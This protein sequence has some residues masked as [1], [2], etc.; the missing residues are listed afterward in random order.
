MKLGVIDYQFPRGGAERFVLGVF[1]SLPADVEVTVFSA[2]SA[3]AGYR[4]LIAQTGR[5]IALVERP[6]LMHQ[7]AAVAEDQAV[8]SGPQ[9]YDVPADLWN[10]LDLVWFPWV[11]RHLIPRECFNRTVATIHD[12]IIV[13]LGEFMAGKREAVGRVGHFYSM[14]MEDMLVRRLMGSLAKVMV[15]TERTRDH[16]AHAY[17]PLTRLPEVVPLSTEHMRTIRPE[18]VDHLGLPERF[19]LYP[20]N[21]SSH[22]NHES[23]FVALAKVKQSRPDAFMPLVLTGGSTPNIASGADYR[24]GYL[25]ALIDHLKLE[26]GR[27]I[28]ILGILND[29]QFRSVLSKAAGLVFPTLLEGYGFP[30]LE[31]GLLGV[32]VACS[33][34]AVMRESMERLKVP[35]LW[36]RPDSP[37]EIAGSLVR[38]AD[39]AAALKSAAAAAAEAFDDLTWADVGARYLQAF[40]DQAMMAAMYQNYGA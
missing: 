34:I 20:A 40:R 17:G 36:F 14:A 38:L 6:V 35:A 31:A 19:V 8:L 15:D 37:D 28:L 30:P 13:E 21:Y 39:D 2:G 10:G 23:L 3:L 7:S 11:N 26:I 5:P 16:L 4:E 29:G 22:K 1:D 9:I 24:G 33:D 32:P 25:K 18:P 27:D 12:M